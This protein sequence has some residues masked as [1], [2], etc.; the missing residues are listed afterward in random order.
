MDNINKCPI[1]NIENNNLWT[2]NDYNG[3]CSFECSDCDIVYADK[4][5]KDHISFYNGYNVNRDTNDTELN[6]KRQICYQQ[7]KNFIDI[8]CNTKNKKILD[9]GCGT[10][11]FL[12][13]FND[14]SYRMGFD[15]DSNVIKLNKKNYSHID[16]V[17]KLD[18]INNV[19]DI[20]IFRGTFQ[21]M[22]NL[23]T[24]KN[25]IDKTL[26][27][28]GILI[29]LSLPNKNSPLALLQREK[30]ALYNPI[31]MF[32]IFSINSIKKVL[33]NYNIV[34]T[35]YPYVK[36]PYCNET[37]DNKKFI[38]LVKN[39]KSSKFAF[40]GSMINIILTKK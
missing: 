9:I 30:W 34:N 1:C 27:N 23:K 17:D 12:E 21:Y 6:N 29:I 33:L 2:S 24:I 35:E 26:V 3:I 14:A 18:S 4:L 31:E 16:F 39:N 8:S 13:L 37:E 38:D 28:N 7:D 32:N 22:R 15:I 11:K 20:I 19:F 40:W 10:G 36:S 25:F 5:I